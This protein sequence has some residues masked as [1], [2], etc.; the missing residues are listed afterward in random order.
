M[1]WNSLVQRHKPL[2]CRRN[3]TIGHRYRTCPRALPPIAQGNL[4]NESGSCRHAPQHVFIRSYSR[5]KRRFAAT[6]INPSPP[7]SLSC[8]GSTGMN[9]ISRARER[10]ALQPDR[11]VPAHR[12]EKESVAAEDNRLQIACPVDLVVNNAGHGHR[13]VGLQPHHL[14]PQ[15]TPHDHAIWT[16]FTTT[17][18][19]TPVRKIHCSPVL[20]ARRTEQ[21]HPSLTPP[22]LLQRH[23]LVTQIR[24]T[25]QTD[26]SFSK[27]PIPPRDSP[28]LS[29]V[30]THRVFF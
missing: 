15:S 19:L 22:C 14:D 5:S 18:D 12:C 29:T 17:G 4:S 25:R 21:N 7:R 1:E 26:I 16:F 10:K 2:K 30:N 3:S 9:T 23:K 13:K 20:L 8:G 6:R 24:E 27:L 11:P 28:L